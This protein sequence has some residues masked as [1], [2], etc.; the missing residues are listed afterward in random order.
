MISCSILVI[1]K[2]WSF[3]S[4]PGLIVVM[5]A[6]G[7]IYD[8]FTDIT[9]L[10]LNLSLVGGLLFGLSDTLEASSTVRAFAGLPEIDEDTG[11]ARR[12]YL[13]L[14][15]RILLVGFFIGQ[16]VL[17][18]VRLSVEVTPLRLVIAA[19]ALIACF[20]VVL[21]FKAR[22]SALFLVIISASLNVISNNWWAKPKDHPERDFRK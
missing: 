16:M 6:Q 5:F 20:L 18:W 21:G 10:C 15:G 4:F 17:A 8:L 14:T 19:L 11:A 7:L 1:I 3:V 22:G 12:K 13:Q 9:F 2:R